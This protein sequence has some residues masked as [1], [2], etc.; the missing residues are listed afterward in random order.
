[1]VN[2][3]DR[4]FRDAFAKLLTK[5]V[6]APHSNGAPTDIF[7]SRDAELITIVRGNVPIVI[8]AGHGGELP[9][10]VNYA[11]AKGQEIPTRPGPVD[12]AEPESEE[13][14]E[15]L[16]VPSRSKKHLPGFETVEDY[17]TDRIAELVFLRL[18]TLLNPGADAATAPL[19]AALEKSGLAVPHLVVARFSREFCDVNRAAPLGAEH[20][21]SLA[22]HEAYHAA[23]RRAVDSAVPGDGL[24]LD[25]HGQSVVPEVALRGTMD[26]VTVANM[27]AKYGREAFDE[28]ASSLFGK[29]EECGLPIGPSGLAW[30]KD[31]DAAKRVVLDDRLAVK[32]LQKGRPGG[33]YRDPPKGSVAEDPDFI[34]GWTVQ[35]YGSHTD[36]ALGDI[37]SYDPDTGKKLAFVA[38]KPPGIDAVQLEV[39][40][41]YRQEGA[42]LGKTADAMAEGIAVYYDHYL[43]KRG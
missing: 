43:P 40:R 23:I 24:L 21:A 20:P 32:G 19:I 38:A 37:F 22:A 6:P 31:G 13:A 26:G 36:I 18:V 35:H 5:D 8:T 30:A 7:A 15:K 11:F 16:F 29:M 25:I 33:E 17:L 34:G 27:L 1:M 2:A 28:T 10:P 3:E 9:I 12:A 42:E 39:G 41:D 14:A 4:F